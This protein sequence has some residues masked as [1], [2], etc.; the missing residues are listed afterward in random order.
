MLEPANAI[1]TLIS[2]RPEVRNFQNLAVQPDSSL[3]P[4]TVADARQTGSLLC[5]DSC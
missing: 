4:L 1:R 3:T 5:A 2:S